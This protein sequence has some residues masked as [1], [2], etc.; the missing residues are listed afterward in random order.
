MADG[1]LNCQMQIYLRPDDHLWFSFS[2][3]PLRIWISLPRLWGLS[4]DG[5]FTILHLHFVRKLL[6]AM[7]LVLQLT[8]F[9]SFHT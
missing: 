4:V 8:T 7:L 2:L 5:L 1:E 6:E 3:L 9:T